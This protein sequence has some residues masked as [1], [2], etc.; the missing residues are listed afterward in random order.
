VPQGWHLNGGWLSTKLTPPRLPYP[1]GYASLSKEDKADWYRKWRESDE[2]KAVLG[3]YQK[4]SDARRHYSFA[5]AD[6]GSFRI[7]DVTPGTY[8]LR[9][10]AEARS[11]NGEGQY[12]ID[13]A[14][15]G[16]L[17]VTV[18]DIPGGRSDEPQDVGTIT[19]TPSQKVRA[20]Q[21]APEFAVKTVDGKPL[22][23]SDFRGKFVLLDFW[24]TWCGPCLAEV[25]HLK[26]VH[27]EFGKNERFAMVSLSLDD[28]PDEPKEFAKKNGLGWTQG[29]LGDWSQDKVTRSYGVQGIP[30]VWLIG[31]DGKVVATGLRGEA[32]APAVREALTR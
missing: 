2:G 17:E 32:I 3:D 15:S 16:S 14:G 23:L 19:F 11:K 4:K 26:K 10:R 6:D 29:F 20:G 30:S 27:E 7:E 24:A 25:P 18:A 8:E 31:P 1:E 28:R 12:V 22:N 21:A 5:V 13:E 9:V